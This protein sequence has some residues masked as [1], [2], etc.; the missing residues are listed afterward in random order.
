PTEW[1]CDFEVGDFCKWI[2]GDGWTVQ[3]GRKAL[4]NKKG[5]SSDHTQGNALGR[6]AYYDPVEGTHDLI[7]PTISTEN[8]DYCFR[9]WYYMHS[10]APISLEIHALQCK[11]SIQS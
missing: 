5:P 7:S 6:Y 2:N 3:D 9:F 10:I 8:S 1:D 11:Y 4:V